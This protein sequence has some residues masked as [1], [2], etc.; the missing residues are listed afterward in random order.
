MIFSWIK[1]FQTSARF[2]PIPDRGWRFFIYRIVWLPDSISRND[3][4]SE[5][6]IS[7]RPW[8]KCLTNSPHLWTLIYKLV[9]RAS[10]PKLSISFCVKRILFIIQF[11][12]IRK[13]HCS[14]RP[15]YWSTSWWAKSFFISLKWF[16][17]FI[18]LNILQN[19][20]MYHSPVKSKI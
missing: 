9:T 20:G 17:L 3:G 16:L 14:L 18:A 13:V 12:L 11:H 4:P 15:F 10:N 7:I 2:S 8:S 1:S 5:L 6:I 19:L